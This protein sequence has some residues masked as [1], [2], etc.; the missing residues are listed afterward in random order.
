MV[1]EDWYF[2]SHRIKLAIY[3]K[4]KGYNVYVCCKNT[5]NFKVIQ[6]EGIHCYDFKSRRKSLST[7]HLIYEVIAFFKCIKK[8]KPEIIHLISMRPA[9]VGLLTSLA[10]KKIKFFVTF[11]GLGFLFIKENTISKILRFLGVLRCVVRGFWMTFSYYSAWLN[12]LVRRRG[13]LR[14]T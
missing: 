14:K 11:T 2:I 3:L 13:D 4:R 6:A 10:F 12:Q 9:V 7:L 8:I 5:G 1:T